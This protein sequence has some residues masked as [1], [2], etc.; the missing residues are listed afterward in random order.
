MSSIASFSGIASGIQW[1]DMIDQ[2]MALERRPAQLLESRIKTTESRSSAWSTFESRVTAFMDAADALRTGSAFRHFTTSLGGIGQGGSA[3]L[4]VSASGDA[5]P[6][7][8][9]VRVLGLAAAEKLS[10]AV[11]AS[12][13]EALGYEGEFLVGGVRVEV[14]ATDSLNDIVERINAANT[15][16]NASGVTASVLSTGADQYR[17]ILTASQTGAAGIDLVDGAAGVLRAL[18]VVD[19]STSIKHAT[20]S[21]ARSDGFKDATTAVATL[22]G[23]ASSNLAGAVTF[24]SGAAQFSAT[25][26]LATMS[27]ADI[28]E[29]INAA[30]AAA[31]SGVQ[32]HV[33]SEEMGGAAVQRLEISGTTAFGDENR[34]LEALGVL[35]AGR[36]AVSQ[37]LEG[38]VLTAGDAATPATADTLLADLWVNGRSA[39][40]QVGDTLT[41]A[42]T[43]GDGSVVELTYTVAAGDTLQDLLDRLNDAIDGFGA[44]SRTATASISADG[45]LTLTD[46]QGGDSRLSLSV[47]AHNEG[48]GTLDFGAMDVAQAGRARQITAGSDAEV[49]I[50]GTYLRHA[51]N[52]ID[53]AIPGLT[54]DLKAASPDTTVTVAIERDV[55]KAVGAVKGMIDAYNAV[56]D[57]VKSQT[58]SGVEGAARPPLSGDSVLRSMQATLRQALETRIADGVAGDFVRLAD[59]GIEI[60]KT[61][62]YTLDSSALES[63]IRTDPGAVM[64]LFGVHGSASNSSLDYITHSDATRPGSY[65]VEITRPA[66]TASIVGTGFTGTYVDDGTPDTLTVRDLGSGKSYAVQLANGMTMADIVAALNSE[67]G[68]ATRH[69]LA[70]SA[71]LFA[72]AAGTVTAD[73]STTFA[74]LYRADGTSAGFEDG[75]TITF[76]GTR[77]NGESFV[78]TFTVSDASTQTLG[79]LAEA[80]EAELGAGV[81]VTIEDGVLT[82]RARE[83]G[84]SLLKL[85]LSADVAGGENPFGTLDV[86]V[87]GRSAARITASD[88]GGQLRLD[89]ELY[90]S[91]E[92]FEISFTA[93]GADGSASLGLAAGSYAGEDVQGTI[94]GF[95]ATGSGRTLTGARDSA[96][97]GLIVRYDGTE[98]GAIGEITFSRGI[99]DEVRRA[100]RI[101][102]GSGD[103][104]IR[105]IVDRLDTS[106]SALHDRI[107]DLED[108]LERRREQLIRRFTAMEEAL[109]NAQSQS[110][111][112]A[113]QLASLSNG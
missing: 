57:F 9:A 74:E 102:T 36:G 4:S 37:R 83:T 17:L 105:S 50:D 39:G 49:E 53:Q 62:R 68:T 70:T 41:L 18:G 40:V 5:A 2:I 69:T 110:Q 108:R 99:A 106:V 21:G 46:D 103:G 55:Q 87:E 33:V 80:I 13:T 16:R 95:A 45:R 75:S 58:S 56:A 38:G 71:A 79:S 77:T 14:E 89:H 20:S 61:G 11:V 82:A 32:A 27:L 60:D 86:A 3:P 91:G 92:G 44:G 90:G 65:A 59:V 84:S 7:T 93:G 94:G 26:D 100:A 35:T 78:S 22:R 85:T 98:T 28:A 76:S 109:A 23:F 47:V 72:D 81:D 1:R 88:D 64:R 52:V 101:L 6:G 97:E 25:I 48:G 67:F 19:D 96:V 31:G 54:L 24:G 51:G 10:G 15:G 30:A 29:A 63:A 43:R 104:S 12:R 42:G 66:A 111:W 113:S 73:A 107:S 34:I 112:L 8:H